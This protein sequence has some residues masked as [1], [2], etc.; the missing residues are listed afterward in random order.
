MFSLNVKGKLL[1]RLYLY[2]Y[3]RR[4]KMAETVLY[5]VDILMSL[6]YINIVVSTSKKTLKDKLKESIK[7]KTVFCDT[8]FV[9]VNL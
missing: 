1:L 4:R 3:P 2:L 8:L 6:W 5:D 9:C 7:G